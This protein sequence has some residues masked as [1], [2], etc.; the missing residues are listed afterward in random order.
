[1][2]HLCIKTIF[3]PRQ[4]RNKHR[5]NSKSR[6]FS[7]RY[8]RLGKEVL[9]VQRQSELLSRR[10][11]LLQVAG[12]LFLACSV[13]FSVLMYLAYMTIA[14]A[15]FAATQGVIQM[16]QLSVRTKTVE[17]SAICSTP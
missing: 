16:Q 6:P 14:V 11:R 9:L 4:A 15:A 8:F 17:R 13:F 3:L 5:K 12:Y 1:L 7:H 10:F 2:S